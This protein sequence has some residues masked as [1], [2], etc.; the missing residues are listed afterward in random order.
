MKKAFFAVLLALMYANPSLAQTDSLNREIGFSTHFVFQNIFSSGEAPVE[1]MYKSQRPSGIWLRYGLRLGASVLNSDQSNKADVTVIK[2]NNLSI[3]PSIGLEK[4]HALSKK[5]GLLYGGDVLVNYTRY[6]RI[7][8]K[9]QNGNNSNTETERS[10]QRG[11][12]YGGA[13]RPFFGITYSPIPRLYLSTE[14]SAY[15]GAAFDRTTFV[16]TRGSETLNDS[17]RD[18]FGG[19]LSLRPA[20][21]IFVYY[22]F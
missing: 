11:H 17:S 5:L 9:L 16:N 13:L 12:S 8:D 14:A 19:S 3:G 15:L 4:R 2:I 7:E 10:N 6:H 18:C 21:A 1:F 20:S 22:R